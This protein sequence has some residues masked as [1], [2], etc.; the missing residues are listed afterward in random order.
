MN[1]L[2]VVAS[3]I[4]TLEVANTGGRM[5]SK[6]QVISNIGSLGFRPDMAVIAFEHA[7]HGFGLCMRGGDAYWGKDNHLIPIKV[8]RKEIHL[9]NL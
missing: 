1:T 4:M 3:R 8:R 7:V 5:K 9:F 6:A 2:K